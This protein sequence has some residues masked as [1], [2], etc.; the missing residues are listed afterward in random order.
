MAT[1]GDAIDYRWP[2]AVWAWEF[3]RRNEDY[4]EAYARYGSQA[5]LQ[6]ILPSGSRLLIGQARY[7]QARK[8]GLLYFANPEFSAFNAGVFWK[9]SLFSAT[10]P[11]SLRD[12]A[13]E[14]Q[15]ARYDAA[16]DTDM[17]ILSELCCQRLIFE[18]INQSRHVLLAPRRLWIQLYCDSAYPFDDNALINFRIQGATHANKRMASV[19]HLLRLHKSTGRKLRAIGYRKKFERLKHALIALDVKQ[20]GG[21][22][23][24][25]GQQ[26][27]PKL[28][29]DRNYREHRNSLKQKSYR[30]LA[31]G[32]RYRDG[33]YLELLT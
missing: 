5:P 2:N 31:R 23:R 4:Q 20:A 27:Y 28:F 17:V 19:Q 15:R 18:S 29:T 6:D 21:S 8:W 32:K 7:E 30:A 25:I 22:Y 3:L 16:S 11:V 12:P 33:K 10:I 9:P 1:K 24:D 26:I 14:K 13:R